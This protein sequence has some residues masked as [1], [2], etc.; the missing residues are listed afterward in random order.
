MTA[1]LLIT[2]HS[3]TITTMVIATLIKIIDLLDDKIKAFII[4]IID[5]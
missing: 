2:I 3:S 1:F 5:Y 4:T